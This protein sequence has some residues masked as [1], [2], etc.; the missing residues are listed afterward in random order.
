MILLQQT[1][2]LF[3]IQTYDIGTEDKFVMH[4]NAYQKIFV[5]LPQP[6]PPLAY[7]LRC[8]LALTYPLL[9]QN[10]IFYCVE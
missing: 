9:N 4:R 8:W 2:D 3:E 1:D 10:T 6:N 5:S 7:S